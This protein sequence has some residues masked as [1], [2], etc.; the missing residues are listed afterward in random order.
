M[1]GL[2]VLAT[3]RRPSVGSVVGATLTG[4]VLIFLLMPILIIIPVSFSSARFLTFPPPGLS[5]QWYH[6]LLEQP[7]W[8][9]SLVTSLKVA[10]MA[11]VISVVLGVLAS[12]ALV[13][14]RFS[15]KPLVY[16]FIL[17]PMILP[18]VIIGLGV[19][20]FFSRAGM[21]GSPLA[22]ALAHAVVNVPVV[23]IIVS[24]T[25][26]SFD[27]LLEQ[28]AIIMGATP[29]TAFRRITLPI[30]APGVISSAVFCFLLSFD[31]LLI[32]LFL[33]SPTSVTLPIQI[34]HNTV[35][36]ISPAIAA[37]STFLIGVSILVLLM[38]RLLRR[39]QG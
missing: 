33:S 21:V 3:M 36:Q 26:Q 34:W 2:N 31:E 12:I 9:R 18:H 15:F 30:I 27:V 39:T 4:L 8:G 13:R 23:V 25:L 17:S 7:E 29:F 28:A 24:A 1:N 10:V 22:I 14:S 37:V 20:F 38:L 6:M 32:A 35:M 5:L 16:A 19:F 11:T